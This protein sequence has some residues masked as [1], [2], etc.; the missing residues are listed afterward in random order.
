MNKSEVWNGIKDF[1][2]SVL[3][4]VRE[5]FQAERDREIQEAK[6]FEFSRG[7]DRAVAALFE[8]TKEKAVIVTLLQKYWSIDMGE[9]EKRV[10]WEARTC[11]PVRGLKRLLKEKKNYTDEE[12]ERF[13][14]DNKVISRL[15]FEP[16]LSTMKPEQLYRELQKYS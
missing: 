5:D 6:E 14:H 1:G 15:R 10:Q 8:V 13:M 4:D 2:N 3:E 12:V 7:L 9:A 16:E 11:A